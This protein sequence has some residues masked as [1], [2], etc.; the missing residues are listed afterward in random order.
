MD[1]FE[2][3][4][5]PQLPTKDPFYSLLAEDNISEIDY[6]RAPKG[7]QPLQHDRPQRLSQL[8]S[9]NQRAFPGRRVREFYG[10]VPPTLWSRSYQ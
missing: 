8:L 10:R 5:E 3:F 7:V 1:S 6:T 2:R 4:Q 9:V